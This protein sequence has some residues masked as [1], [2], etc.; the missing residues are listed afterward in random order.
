ML[1]LTTAEPAASRGAALDAKVPSGA[2]SQGS[3]RSGAADPSDA[4]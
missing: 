1:L 4:I 3:G 2:G